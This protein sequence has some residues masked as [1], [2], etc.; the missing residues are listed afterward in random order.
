[1]PITIRYTKEFQKQSIKGVFICLSCTSTLFAPDS[2]FVAEA[3]FSSHASVN[4]ALANHS[5]GADSIGCQF[6]NPERR[7]SPQG[8]EAVS[9]HYP[10]RKSSSLLLS[11]SVREAR[12]PAAGQWERL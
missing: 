8:R 10:R 1:M 9:Q 2:R 3:A 11:A 6:T 4:M 5:P 7:T 12:A